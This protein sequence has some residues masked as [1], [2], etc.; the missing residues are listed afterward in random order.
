MDNI[1]CTVRAMTIADYGDVTAL[2]LRSDGI[3]LSESDTKQRV[4]AFLERNPGLSAVA[5]GVGG[6]IL[7]AVLCGHDG[8]RGYLHHLVVATAHRRRGIARRLV[9]HCFAGLARA[10]ILKCNIF[11]LRE[12]PQSISFWTYNGWK[13]PTWQVM[14]KPIDA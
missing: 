5:E 6:E 4:D 1:V 10:R 9:Q 11:V 12:S 3:G 7:G 2:W 14:Q 13:A 8:R